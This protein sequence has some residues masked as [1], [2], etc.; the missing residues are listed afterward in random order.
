MKASELAKIL[1]ED[2]FVPPPSDDLGTRGQSARNL[3]EALSSLDISVDVSRE[4]TSSEIEEA[5]KQIA[6]TPTLGH[7]TKEHI[8]GGLKEYRRHYLLTEE[9]V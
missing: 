1:E 8:L 4:A 3:F 2:G 9:S 7:F 6:A 5:I